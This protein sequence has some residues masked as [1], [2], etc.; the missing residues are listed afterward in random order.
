MRFEIEFFRCTK[1]APDGRIIRRNT[2]QFASQRD[3]ALTMRPDGADGFR[4]LQ[5]GT[6]RKTVSIQTGE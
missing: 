3:V 5:N 4:I 1:E 6:L 2:G